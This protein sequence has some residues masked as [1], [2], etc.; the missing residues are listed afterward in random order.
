MLFVAVHRRDSG[1]LFPMSTDLSPKLIALDLDGT[2]L[3]EGGR[4]TG[5]AITAIEAVVDAGF[6]AV[7][8]TGR[9]PHMVIPVTEALFGTVR[10]VVGGNGSIISTFPETIEADAELL[11]VIGF[12][13]DDAFSVVATLRH[14]DAGFGFALATD[15]GFAH[16]PGFA[17]LM[18]AAVHDDPVSDVTAIGGTQAFKLLA[19][20]ATQP[21]HDLITTVPPLIGG[22]T[23]TELLVSHMGADAVEIGPAD[24]DKCTG[25]RWLCD[26]LGV[27]AANVIAIGDEWN[28]LTMLGWAGRGV[29]MGNADDRVKAVADEVIGS[30]AE[31]GVAIFLESLLDT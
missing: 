7:I 25:L 8:A 13:I 5:R 14:H 10:H 1:R 27:P 12:D 11:H 28:D 17:D 15:A 26:H 6:L 18:P 24:A 31:N 23:S 21:V 16:E 22:R 9:P 20:H 29:A 19:F 4:V 3:D 30:H 2:L